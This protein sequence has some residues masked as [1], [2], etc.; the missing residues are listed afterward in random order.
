SAQPLHR[1]RA[2]RADH[3]Y[4]RHQWLESPG[5]QFPRGSWNLSAAGAL[6]GR[7]GTCMKVLVAGAAGAIGSRLVPML[8][9]AGHQVTGMTRLESKAG[10][11][12]AAGAIPAIV[13]AL[14]RDAVMRAV[15]R[16]APEVIVHEL[17]AIPGNLDFR[18]FGEQFAMTNRLRTEG[19]DN[20]IAA[21]GE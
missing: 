19:L 12:R 20:L 4:R 3:G 9:Q 14:D 13:N 6:G 15:E 18:H 17:T 11:I 16:A 1:K 21:A 7:K 2:G 5:D 8:V 10:R